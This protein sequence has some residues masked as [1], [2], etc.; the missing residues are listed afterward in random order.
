[1]AD[2]TSVA[3]SGNQADKGEADGVAVNHP[4]GR[5]AP[6]ESGGGDYPAGSDA[7]HD[8]DGGAHFDGGQSGKGYH[9]GGQAGMD[10]SSTPNATTRGSDSYSDQGKAGTAPGPD[11]PEQAPHAEETRTIS[12]GER[13]FDV[14]ETSGTAIAEEAGNVGREGQRANDAGTPGAG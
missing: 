9:G 3:A 12:T 14:V 2:R 13:T 10:G 6:G 5:A 8:R 1:M 11:G 4:S 7:G